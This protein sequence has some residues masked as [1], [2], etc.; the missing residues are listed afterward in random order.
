M[1]E[2]LLKESSRT[3]LTVQNQLETIELHRIVE[4]LKFVRAYET[5]REKDEQEPYSQKPLS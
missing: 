3:Y 4:H 5:G 2:N 1:R